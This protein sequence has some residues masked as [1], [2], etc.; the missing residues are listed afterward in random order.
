MKKKMLMLSIICLL[1]VTINYTYSAFRNTIIGNINA[2][3]NN[4]YFAVNATNGTLENDYFK[5]P[6]SGTSGSF[7]IT[8]DTT[9]N[10]SDVDYSIE[11]SGYNLPSDI[12][13]Y[14]DS[15][16]SS[17]ISNNVYSNIAVKNTTETITIYYKS[18][19]TISGYVYAKVKGNVAIYA[20]MKNGASNKTEFWSDTYRPYIKTISFGNDLSNLP[21]ECTEENLCWDISYDANQE[22]KVYGYLVDSGSTINETD[23]SSNTTTKTLYNLYIVS[24]STVFAP[25]DCNNLFSMFNRLE[26]INFNKNFNTLKITN[27]DAMF[28][29]CISL[30]SLDLSGFNTSNVTSMYGMFN[31]CSSLTTL[32]LSNFDTSKVTSMEWMFNWCNNLISINLSSFNTLN[33]TNMH[34]MFR[35]CTRLTSLD[36]SNFN[37]S[38]VTNMNSMFSNC[39]KITTTINVMNASVTDYA[40]MFL[41][42]ATDSNAQITVNYI[43]D[44]S[45]LVDQMI[46]TKSSTSNVIKGTVIS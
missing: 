37:T 19:S 4:W 32:D 16:Y 10:S 7:D 8:L 43:N 34:N 13:Y 11:L 6:I 40:D 44:A 26:T 18:S 33:V 3:S 30:T 14:S 2:T 39:S 22:I 31:T 5:I 21:S 20:M 28:F 27:M 41:D 25:N 36:L 46:A 29:Y 15:N 12:E 9:N 17:L 42:S 24:E 45:D 1:F 35:Y 38:S 23:E